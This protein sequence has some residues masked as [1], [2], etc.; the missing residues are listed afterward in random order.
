M[1]NYSSNV[2]ETVYIA[3]IMDTVI[4]SASDFFC[5]SHGAI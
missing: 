5:F 3:I 4:Q 2:T 1:F